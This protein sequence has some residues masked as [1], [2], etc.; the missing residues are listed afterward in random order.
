MA[1]A[2]SRT[3]KSGQNVPQFV[4]GDDLEAESQQRLNEAVFDGLAVVDA[5]VGLGQAADQETLVCTKHPVIHLN[6][7]INKGSDIKLVYL[8]CLTFV[9]F[10]TKF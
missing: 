6:L 3:G 7:N 5:G 9:K 10:H 4:C 2:A 1:Q 8:L